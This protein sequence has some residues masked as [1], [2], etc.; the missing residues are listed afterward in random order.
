MLQIFFRY[1]ENIFTYNFE[2]FLCRW[3]Q[4]KE[5]GS[6]QPLGFYP[7]KREWAGEVAAG[8][9]SLR[10]LE[11]DSSYDTGRYVCQVTAS[12]FRETDTLISR[13]AVLSVR[14]ESGFKQRC[15]SVHYVGSSWL[16]G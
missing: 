4:K 13:E 6:V 1:S 8:D 10:I 3:E 15:G 9:C 16:C 14:G 5:D 2:Y 7:G 12:G 11:A